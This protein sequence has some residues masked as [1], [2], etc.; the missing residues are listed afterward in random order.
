MTTLSKEDRE[1]L[2]FILKKDT[3]KII[4]SFENL[5]NGICDSLKRQEVTVDNLVRVAVHSDSS[6]HDKLIKS[7]SI[8]RVFTDLAPEMSFFNHETLIRIINVLGDGDD[9]EHLARYSKEFQEFCKRKVFEIE[10][11]PCTCGQYLSNLKQRKPFAVVLPT[12]DKRLQNLGDAIS[13]KEMVADV[14]G[15]PLATLH[16]HRIDRGS[17]ILVFSVPD[18]I[19]QELY[20]LPKEKLALLRAKG[21]VLFVPQDFAYESNQVY[22]FLVFS[23]ECVHIIII[24]GERCNE[25]T[26]M[27][28]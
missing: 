21:M 14:L 26:C 6:L 8:D 27:Q 13:V 22:T 10:P 20:P 1:N 19:A 15:V 17:I 12:G 4:R 9:K 11:G 2:N 25:T 18:S 5:S 3:K 16:L 28:W 23:H 24:I 7:T